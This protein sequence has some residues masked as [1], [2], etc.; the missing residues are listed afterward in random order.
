MPTRTTMNETRTTASDDRAN[1]PATTRLAAAGTQAVVLLICCV[2]ILRSP[3]PA[4]GASPDVNRPSAVSAV[5]S[6]GKSNN[7]SRVSPKPAA[8]STSPD[9]LSVAA[10]ARTPAIDLPIEQDSNSVLGDDLRSRLWKSRIL[11]PDPNEDIATKDT[12]QDLIQ[13]LK[14]VTLGRPEGKLT[15]LMTVAIEKVPPA[16]K[17]ARLPQPVEIEQSPFIAQASPEPSTIL[18]AATLEKLAHLMQDPNQVRNPLEMAE[19][20]FLSNRPVEA[21]AF[22]EKAL[23]L[24]APNDPATS[25]DRAWILFQWG[26]SL[27]QTDMT[28]AR[29]IYLKLI[30]EFPNSPWTELAKANGRLISWYQ[31]T[32]PQQLIAS[33]SP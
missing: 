4:V 2:A 8:V 22:Y 14:T 24:T 10:V 30:S 15:P 9:S 19:L 28:K 16:A 12:L 27:R 17:E 6:R 21:A 26:T 1:R 18:P 33:P 11:P 13:R 20:L 32:K 5:P 7:P 23:A 29:D 25:D 3:L 31:S